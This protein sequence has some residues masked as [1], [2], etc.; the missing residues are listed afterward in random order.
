MLTPE[1]GAQA[2][3]PAIGYDFI[4]QLLLSTKLPHLLSLLLK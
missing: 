1:L 2:H 3:S 4:W